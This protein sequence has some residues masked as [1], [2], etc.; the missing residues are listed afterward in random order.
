MPVTA[1]QQPEIDEWDAETYETADIWQEVY[2]EYAPRP[3]PR[4][5][6]WAR[7]RIVNEFGRPYDHLAY[8]HLGAP[9][10]PW[11]AWDNS[12][13]RTISLQF[14]TRLGKTFFGLC[15]CLFVA[16][17]KPAPGM[18]A[19]ATEQLCTQV[20]ER[21]YEMIRR[22]QVL[23]DLLAA[24]HETEWRQTEYRF[25]GC[26]VFGAWAR[27]VSTLADKDVLFGHAAE[28]DKW[29]HASTSKEADPLALFTDRFKNYQ[30]IRKQI[31]ESTPTIRGKSRIED[32][33]N[34]GTYCRLYVPCP[35]CK[36]H[37][38][39]EIGDESL[40]YGLK[41]DRSASGKSDPAAAFESAKYLCKHCQTELRD[42][43]R[44]WMIRRGVWVP[45]GCDVESAA[46]IEAAESRMRPAEIDKID[47]WKGWK[48]SPWITGTPA[49]DGVDHSYQLS[50]LYALSL[51][52]GD[53]ASEFVKCHDKPQLLRNFVNQW[54]A[55]TWELKRQAHSSD[56]LAI[57]LRGHHRR[58]I[59]PDKC[60]VITLG[61]D[62]QESH[63]VW[64]A[65]GWGEEDRAYVVDYGTVAT[66]QEL[67]RDV[68]ANRFAGES[69]PELPIS[70][71]GMDSG[72]RT[73]EVFGYCQ[74]IGDALRPTKGFDMLDKPIVP[75]S[76]EYSRSE[77]RRIQAAAAKMYLWKFSK[78]YWHEELQR[79]LDVLS[80]GAPGSL[81]IP[82][83][84][85]EDWDF[86]EQISNNAPVAKPNGK[87]IWEKIRESHPDDYRDALVIALVTKEMWTR[88]SET[89]VS[90]ALN[91]RER[92]IGKK[93]AA[94]ATNG[95]PVPQ[96][97]FLDRPG[98][99]I[100]GMD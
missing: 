33:I 68:L 36:R 49:R 63:F 14:G 20:M 43:D 58:G 15:C 67:R 88:G 77:D 56:E 3:V 70:M 42:Y 25:K 57:R 10:G 74:E 35:Q 26:K 82:R 11:D 60:G 48:S 34:A 47:K 61:I 40:P 98:G 5:L 85:V 95:R 2:K 18:H 45:R 9:G 46:A 100:G 6:A 97:R 59:V 44:A 69:L 64:V 94:S 39:L 65:V 52:W 17:N 83:D 62:V 30:S 23:K 22:R 84:S 80:A 16:E 21:G 93:T 53:I 81:S 4:G 66:W 87:I 37:Q 90:L 92:S 50:S 24:K 13:V 7:G 96:K 73:D 51:S 38:T 75:S 41:F 55:E 72:H 19:N 78:A 54:K 32:K 1:E 28:I 89:R 31:F 29:E 8:P 99:W 79:R 91:S 71:G 86:I 27:S 12:A 76:L